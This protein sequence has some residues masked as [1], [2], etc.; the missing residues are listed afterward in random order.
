MKLPRWFRKFVY[1]GTSSLHAGEE[2][3]ISVV[4]AALDDNERR[5]LEQQ[6]GSIWLGGSIRGDTPSEFFVARCCR[7]CEITISRIGWLF[8]KWTPPHGA[9]WAGL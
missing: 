2:S 8:V 7:P 5:L 1:G 3:L 9:R 4:L 6:I